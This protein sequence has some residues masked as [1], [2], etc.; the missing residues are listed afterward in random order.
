MSNEDDL[1][2][3]DMTREELDFAWDLWFDLAQSTNDADAPYT[4]GVVAGP[5]GFASHAS[6]SRPIPPARTE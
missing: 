5:E 2:I 3:L 1:N 6:V 4:H